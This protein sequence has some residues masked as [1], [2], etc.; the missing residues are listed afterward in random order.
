MASHSNQQEE[1]RVFVIRHG[2]RIDHVDY[3]WVGKSDRPYDPPLTEQGVREA[4]DAGCMLKERV[5]KL[6]LASCCVRYVY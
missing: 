2:E 5:S 1:Q 3:S 4:K 6:Y